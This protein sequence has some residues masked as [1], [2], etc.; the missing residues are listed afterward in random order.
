MRLTDHTDYALRVLMYLGAHRDRL[1]TID[2][3]ATSH[4]ISRNHLTKV[5]HRL[6][7]AGF[8]TTVR[9]RSGGMRLAREPG[10]IS[11]GA[12]VRSTEPDFHLVECLDDVRNTCV[13]SETCALK[14]VLASAS[15]HFL[16][17]LDRISLAHVL[18]AGVG[19]AG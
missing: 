15:H 12:V 17:E 6:G 18:P 13:I 19:S 11:I 7:L 4:G 14:R 9:G 2:E 5:V 8:V 16:R 1:A 10:A 3:V